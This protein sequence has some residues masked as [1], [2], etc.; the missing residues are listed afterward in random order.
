MKAA[1]INAVALVATG[2]N[3]D[4]GRE[5]LGLRVAT[6]ETRAAWNSFFADLVA[7]GLS[8]VRLVTSDAHEGLVEAIA[9]NLPGASW[10]RCRTHYAANLMSVT[11]KTMWP[12]VKA[13]L[14]SVDD[15]PD[16]DAVHARFDRLLDYVDG[17]P[18]DAHEHLD[19]AQADIL[20]SPPSPRD[21][22]NR[23]GPTTRTSDSTGRSAAAPTPSASSPTA[24]PSS[25]SSAP[26][27]PNRPTNGPKDA[28]TSASTSSP[29]PA[30]P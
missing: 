3:S 24:T 26:S 19:A 1:E 9:A 8:G 12:A 4:G 2:V 30:S 10:Q 27:S 16:A 14:H 21:S 20:A 13:M 17:K 5:V 11:P 22:G 28:A 15:Q 6:S 29:S 23:S 7:P 18:P 25:V